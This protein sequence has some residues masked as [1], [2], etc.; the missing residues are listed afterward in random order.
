VVDVRRAY[1]CAVLLNG[2]DDEQR[3]V[4]E[5]STQ[6][7]WTHRRQPGEPSVHAELSVPELQRSNPPRNR[8]W[9]MS[10][11]SGEV[12]PRYGRGIMGVN[13]DRLVNQSSIS[14]IYTEGGILD[15]ARKDEKHGEPALL[16]VLAS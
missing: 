16:R 15:M 5:V 2:T 14:A 3:L 6:G 7:S 11:G 13:N 8:T 4:G 9:G 10:G 12:L 1:I